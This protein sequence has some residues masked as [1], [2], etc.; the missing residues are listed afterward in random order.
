MYNCNLH[1]CI[2]LEKYLT[3]L[4]KLLY[5]C[6]ISLTSKLHHPIYISMCIQCLYKSFFFLMPK[7]GDHSQSI[8][9]YRNIGIFCLKLYGKVQDSFT[10]FFLQENTIYYNTLREHIPHK[11]RVESPLNFALRQAQALS[12]YESPIVLIH[13]VRQTDVFRKNLVKLAL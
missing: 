8:I 11:W 6:H 9:Y 5:L 2:G 10:S 13:F 1:M 7:Q 3:P 4:G 12:R